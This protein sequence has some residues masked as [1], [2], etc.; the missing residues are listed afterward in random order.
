[1][2]PG[3]RHDSQVLVQ[4]RSQQTLSAQKSPAWQ[5]APRAQGPPGGRS[6]T[7]TPTVQWAASMQSVSVTHVVGQL[8]GVCT[9]APLQKM[10]S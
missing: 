6:G 4:A 5:S 7:Q 2:L 1:M 9:S 8:R 3:N 10:G